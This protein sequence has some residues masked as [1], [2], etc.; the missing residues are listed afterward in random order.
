MVGSHGPNHKTYL[1]V[2]ALP[3]TLDVVKANPALR[4]DNTKAIFVSTFCIGYSG[5]T[6]L[7]GP[8]PMFFSENPDETAQELKN[9]PKFAFECMQTLL[10][11]LLET[12]QISKEEAEAYLAN[13]TIGRSRAPLVRTWDSVAGEGS[14]I[15]HKGKKVLQ[16][17]ISN[18]D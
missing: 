8:K 2:Q 1:H 14:G 11:R 4:L 16:S 18:A 3:C 5:F 10:G 6:N 7:P 12:E 9:S 15:A 17:R 13:P